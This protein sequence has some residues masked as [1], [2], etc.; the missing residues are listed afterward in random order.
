MKSTLLEITLAKRR[1][2]AYL[3]QENKKTA[4]VRLEDGRYIKI[5]KRRARMA[6]IRTTLI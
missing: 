3:L 6:R 1:V 2:P 4:H 5:N